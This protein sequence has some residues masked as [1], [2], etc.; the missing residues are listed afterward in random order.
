M[1]SPASSFAQPAQPAQPASS[2]GL[3]RLYFLDWLRVLAFAYL[4]IY[5]TGLMYVSWSWHISADYQ[6][7]GLKLVLML[8]SLWRLDLLFFVSG[9]AISYMITK[10]SIKDFVKSRL[11]RLLIPLIFGTLIVMGPQAYF[12][13][14][15]KGL[16]DKSY[17]DFYLH[18][19]LSFTWKDG[20]SVPMP[21]YYQLW[22]V[23]YLLVYSLF[24]IP[25][26]IWVKSEKSQAFCAALDRLSGRYYM[27]IW[28]PIC[29]YSLIKITLSDYPT[30]HA[31]YD[32]WQRHAVYLFILMLGILMVRM[33]GIWQKIEAV[34]A[35]VLVLALMGYALLLITYF[36]PD[37]V[38]FAYQEA[39]I[40][41]WVKWTWILLLIGAARKFLSFNS[42]LLTQLNGAVYP[43][44]ILHQSLL[45]S[46]G[47]YIAM[48]ALPWWA[49]FISIIALTYAAA[50]LIYRVIIL[51]FK[52]LRLVF[53]VKA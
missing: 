4:V 19:Y 1:A 10:I 35:P 27:L 26:L 45:I 5:H 17:W 12:E 3:Q 22:Y 16:T 9:V 14:L 11:T 46:F 18:D 7:E 43:F 23:L 6:S 50:W 25:F 47:Y 38:L 49:Q 21:V 42:P 48:S 34:I 36:K 51:P 44:F 40:D 39:L 29:V 52:P 31:L 15:Q 41:A 13:A 30:T 8:S 32:D 53:G 2:G 28:L 20:M 37:W 33:P 24:L